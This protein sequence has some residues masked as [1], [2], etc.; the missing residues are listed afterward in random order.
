LL[1]D[2]LAAWTAKVARLQMWMG[3]QFALRAIKGMDLSQRMSH[4]VHVTQEDSQKIQ[5]L[6]FWNVCHVNWEN[7]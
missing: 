4:V 6:A 1:L 3:S 7:G 5:L 2:S